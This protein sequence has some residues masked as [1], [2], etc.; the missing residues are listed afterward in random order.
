MSSDLI[1]CAC[2]LCSAKVRAADAGAVLEGRFLVSKES[3]FRHCA[4]HGQWRPGVHFFTVGSVHPGKPHRLRSPSVRRCLSVQQVQLIACGVY[5]YPQCIKRPSRKPPHKS[6]NKSLQTCRMLHQLGR[7]EALQMIWMQTLVQLWT[8]AILVRPCNQLTVQWGTKALACMAHI[9]GHGLWYVWRM[10]FYKLW[11]QNEVCMHPHHSY[12]LSCVCRQS[13]VSA[14][15]RAQAARQ[16]RLQAP[17]PLSTGVLPQVRLPLCTDAS[18]H[19]VRGAAAHQ[20][21]QW[22]VHAYDD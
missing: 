5:M 21:N 3:A 14:G 1:W 10:G 15:A 22:Q 19:N 8:G 18:R 12:Y 2:L 20:G 17:R 9:Y 16:G 11:L 7:Q 6:P 4:K 13:Y